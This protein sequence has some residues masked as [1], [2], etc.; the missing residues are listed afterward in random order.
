MRGA[1]TLSGHKYSLWDHHP[2]ARQ[3]NRQS[4]L[5]KWNYGRSTQPSEVL[6]NTT[7]ADVERSG[8]N[9]LELFEPRQGIYRFPGFLPGDAYFIKALQVE[10]ELRA[11]PKEV[12]E[13]QGCVASNCPL[14]VQD[15][16]YPV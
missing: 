16:G 12:G 6:K 14:A 9:A 4:G 11:R 2:N 3:L 7:A 13:T 1:P 15:A 10:P 5:L 8:G